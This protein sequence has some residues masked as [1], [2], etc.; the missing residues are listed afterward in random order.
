MNPQLDGAVSDGY[1][2][3]AG[4]VCAPA[5]FTAAGVAAGIKLG[6]ALDLALIVSDRPAA[7]AAWFT[8][9]RAAAAPVVI[10]REHVAGGVARAVVVNSGCANAMTGARGC[11][12]AR[13]TADGV[14]ALLGTTP[15]LIL[16]C[17]TGAIGTYLP[18]RRLLTG[19]RLAAGALT[20]DDA[21]AARA[22]MTTDT[23][24]KTAAVRSSYGWS[25]GGM[26][27]GAGMLAPNTAT[28][29][30]V[31]TTD[32]RVTPEVLRTASRTAVERTFHAITVDGETSTNDTIAILANGAADVTP[33]PE[34]LVVALTEVC[35]ALARQLISDAEGATKEVLVRVKGAMDETQASQASRLVAQSLLVKCA[36]HGG[37]ANWGQVAAALGR[38]QVEADFDRLSIVMGGV[39]VLDAGIPAGPDAIALARAGLTHRAIVVECSLAVGSAH[40]EMLTTDLS[41]EYARLNSELVPDLSRPLE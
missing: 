8:T 4:G 28:M 34:E 33:T 21:T 24:P 6:G 5:G 15:D 27:K 25:V 13:T 2:T 9:N 22:I 40:A 35:W 1:L 16:V 12:D 20:N 19:A 7:A 31:I 26:A 36:L 11:N 37:D 23:R 18:I 3:V 30:S 17:S 14:A 10:S 29:L 32:A 41:P 38:S 39:T